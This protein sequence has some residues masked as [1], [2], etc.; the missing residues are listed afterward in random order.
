MRGFITA[1]RTLTILPIRGKD[2]E[3]FSSSLYW[4]PAI[5]L[6]LGCLLYAVATGIDQISREP[7][8]EFTALVILLLS[9]T[10]TRA[11]HLDGLSDWAD[12]F[13]GGYDKERILAIMKDSS[14]GTFGGAA[15]IFILLAKWVCIVRL[16]DTNASRW[17]ISAFIISRSM[18]AVLASSFPY[19]RANGGTGESFVKNAG[20]R[21][22]YTALSA[23][24]LLVLIFG[25]PNWESVAVFAVAWL[26]T[27][28]FGAYSCRKIGGITGD[29][30]GTLNELIETGI[31]A[32]GA[33]LG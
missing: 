7:W 26:A 18:Q 10:L 16:I 22:K 8:P 3:E 33:V 27:L 1:F 30:I 21:H 32:S 15:L 5:G 24:I 2:A 13:W 12:G 29:I 11:L 9:I 20:N 31:L 19:A 6:I 25:G 4:F 17:I 28:L 23:A 14:I